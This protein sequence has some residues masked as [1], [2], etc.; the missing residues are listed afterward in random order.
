MNMHSDEAERPLAGIT[1]LDLTRLLP[2]PMATM[3][4]ADMGATV[5]KIEDKGAGDYARTMSHV[6][7]ELSQLFIAVNREKIHSTRSQGSE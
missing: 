7:N 1:V 4:L 5:I 6:R 2:G 3:H